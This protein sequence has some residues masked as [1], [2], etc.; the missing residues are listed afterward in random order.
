MV[1]SL[2]PAERGWAPARPI[3]YETESNALPRITQGKTAQNHAV[4]SSSRLPGTDNAQGRLT[5]LAHRLMISGRLPRRY[6]QRD[7]LTGLHIAETPARVL[8]GYAL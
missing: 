6:R 2:P 7:V 1:S 4:S 3:L 5:S 8:R